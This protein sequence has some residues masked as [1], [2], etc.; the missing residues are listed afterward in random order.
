MK[1]FEMFVFASYITDGESEE[2]NCFHHYVEA[3]DAKAAE[4]LA[5]EELASEGYNHIEIS[6]VIATD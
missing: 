6:D 2:W 3:P 4:V 1:E 5:R